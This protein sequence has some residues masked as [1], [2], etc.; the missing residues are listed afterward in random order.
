MWDWSQQGKLPIVI[1]TTSCLHTLRTCGDVLDGH[2]KEVW[3]R[4]TLLDS[5]EFLH[6]HVL[7]GL[8]LH[9]V[10]QTVMLHPNCSARKLGLDGRL[11]AIA[12]KCAQSASVPLN[13]GCCAYAGDRGLL[14][15]ELTAS[16]TEEESAEVNSREY[17][18]YYSSN[19]TC[20]MGMSESTGKDYV[21]IVYLVEKASR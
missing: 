1:D 13:L 21:G 6:D 15:P 16:A 4:L 17:G 18:G 11:L 14:Y 3:S 19:I 2:D 5:I 10:E 9:P 7:P 12:K 20:E 8:V